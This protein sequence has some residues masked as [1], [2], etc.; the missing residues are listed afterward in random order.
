ML[1][2]EK[3]LADSLGQEPAFTETVM[4]R[5]AGAEVRSDAQQFDS[6]EAGEVEGAE[7]DSEDLDMGDFEQELTQ[8]LMMENDYVGE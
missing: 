8:L 1:T 6:P 4:Q 3:E 2:Y 5:P 7:S